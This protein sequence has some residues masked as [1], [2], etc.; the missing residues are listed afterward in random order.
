MF[1]T[2]TDR[3]I[4]CADRTA[5]PQTIGPGYYATDT[6]T[7]RQTS[8]S[9]PAPFLSAAP[10]QSSVDILARQREFIPAPGSYDPNHDPVYIR[11]S[12]TQSSVFASKQSRFSE[13]STL[14]PGPGAYSNIMPTMSKAGHRGLRRADHADPGVGKP[15][16]NTASSIPYRTPKI[17][18]QL[19]ILDRSEARNA[20]IIKQSGDGIYTPGPGTYTDI[21]RYPEPLPST[22]PGN[23]S[24]AP[25]LRRSDSPLEKSLKI[26]ATREMQMNRNTTED[27]PSVVPVGGAS[28][29]LAY[30]AFLPRMKKL[31][32]CPY[33]GTSWALAPSRGNYPDQDSYTAVGPGDYDAYNDTMVQRVDMSKPSPAFSSRIDRFASTTGRGMENVAPG[34]YS[35]DH[36]GSIAHHQQEITRQNELKREIQR[37]L[38]RALTINAKLHPSV[39]AASAPSASGTLGAS[40]PD[41]TNSANVSKYGQYANNEAYRTAPSYLTPAEKSSINNP[42]VGIYNTSVD[43]LDKYAK[44]DFTNDLSTTAITRLALR[45]TFGI[46]KWPDTPVSIPDKVIT[47]KQDDA[48]ARIAEEVIPYSIGLGAANTDAIRAGIASSVNVASFGKAL[49]RNHGLDMANNDTAHLAPGTYNAARAYDK[50]TAKRDFGVRESA[51]FA[52]MDKR[53]TVYAIAESH[54]RDEDFAS[55]NA[56]RLEETAAEQRAVGG[57]ETVLSYATARYDGDGGARLYNNSG[58]ERDTG[59]AITT[60]MNL[61]NPGAGSY[62]ICKPSSTRAIK[63]YMHERQPDA[64]AVPEVLRPE[65]AGPSALNAA[66]VILEEKSRQTPGPGFYDTGVDMAKRSFNILAEDNV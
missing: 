30:P 2:R 25:T 3:K 10:T 57:K 29:S 60:G 26:R 19:G 49:P 31:R 14:P 1:T 59:K 47:D 6:S 23:A 35:V 13:V 12:N 11:G 41:S 54:A 8:Y 43:S 42:P 51:P 56:K 55:E 63:L 39:L 15:S 27:P 7:L 17:P 61:D 64:L 53:N 65:V 24:K 46:N 16:L 20:W 50:L 9:G 4:D 40:V 34:S 32:P 37:S 18:S 28:S 66:Q 22:S 48:T 5:V 44:S 36:Y 33:A 52:S 45:Q 21:E 62:D 58:T 38:K